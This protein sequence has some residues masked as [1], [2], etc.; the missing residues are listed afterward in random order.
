MTYW[1]EEEGEFLD[2][3]NKAN[4]RLA[5]K[6]QTEVNRWADKLCREN[7]SGSFAFVFR[8]RQGDAQATKLQKIGVDGSQ[9]DWEGSS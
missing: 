4:R 3:V 2:R 6:H 8:S 7:P 5:S 9:I 1:A